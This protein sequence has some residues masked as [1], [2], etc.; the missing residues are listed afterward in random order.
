MSCA[1][2]PRWIHAAEE[3]PYCFEERAGHT[4]NIGIG[5]EGEKLPHSPAQV[6]AIMQYAMKHGQLLMAMFKIGDDLAVQVFG[7]PSEEL[8]NALDSTAAS[9]RK[10]V[11][12][13]RKTN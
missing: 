4:A 12:A 3:C 1:F 10:A 13:S 6:E 7:E 8:A 5:K 9:Y 11:D 2:H